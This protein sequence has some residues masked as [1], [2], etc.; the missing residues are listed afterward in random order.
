MARQVI[1]RK[2]ISTNWQTKNPILAS[3]EIGVDITVNNIK[4]GDGTNTWNDLS[5]EIP[6]PLTGGAIP[7]STP[8][9]LG[10]IF[11]DTENKI[12]YMAV[13]TVDATGWKQITN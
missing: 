5:Y 6:T 8:R 9:Y 10:Q 3:G 4:I 13:N 1:L 2:D 11:I 7:T 12:A